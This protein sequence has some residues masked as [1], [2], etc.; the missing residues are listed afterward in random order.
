MHSI[1]CLYF[2]DIVGRLLGRGG[3]CSGKQCAECVRDDQCTG[4]REVCRDYE[5]KSWQCRHEYE[6]LLEEYVYTCGY[7]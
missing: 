6:S 4:N 7:Y 3:N 1:C 2:S 5:C